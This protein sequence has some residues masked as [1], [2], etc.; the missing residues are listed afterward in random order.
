MPAGFTETRVASAIS[1]PTSLDIAHDGRVFIAQQNGTIR[2]IKNDSL[3]SSPF[4]KLTV[5]SNGER[6]LLG[7]TLD[8][9]FDTQ[10]LRLRLLHRHFAPA[11]TA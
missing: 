1:S 7:I 3:L 4:A 2:I 5:D 8:P 10:R 11:T 9:N 6:G